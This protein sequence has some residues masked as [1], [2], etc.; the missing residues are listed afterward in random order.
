MDKR[1]EIFMLVLIVLVLFF[2]NYSYI[3]SFAVKIAD[4]REEVFVLRVI[5]GDTIEITRNE[6]LKETIRL[7]GINTPERGEKYY[8]EAKEFLESLILNRT[9]ELEKLREDKDKYGRSLRYAFI[10]GK[11]VNIKII[12]EG[13][14]NAY[15]PSGKDKHAESFYEAWNQCL[16]EGEN[17]CE[18]SRD[19]CANCIELRDLSIKNS[20]AVLMNKCPFECE[21]DGW[22]LRGE[23]RK[24]TILKGEINPGEII[25]MKT[26]NSWQE[27][28]DSLFLRDEKGNLILHHHY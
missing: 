23:G 4:G 25:K 21:V 18:K 12:E 11:N 8:K 5:D 2:V 28:G 16:S 14:A 3:D 22:E 20:E 24:K 17:L 6:T 9:I 19:K 7:L 1:K 15:F 27:T 26:E 13:F 10:N